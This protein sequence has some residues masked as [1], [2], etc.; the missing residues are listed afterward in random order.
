MH[1]ADPFALDNFRR[2][3]PIQRNFEWQ[4]KTEWATTVYA[5]HSLDYLMDVRGS[6]DAK[7]YMLEILHQNSSLFLPYFERSEPWNVSKELN[8]SL[9]IF[10]WNL[11]VTDM[12]SSGQY[13]HHSK[14]KPFSVRKKHIFFA[15][16]DQQAYTRPP[17]LWSAFESVAWSNRNYCRANLEWHWRNNLFT[18]VK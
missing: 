1:W 5:K 7:C 2:F 17:S 15:F 13:N 11:F 10:G 3:L 4:L 14:S 9:P 18:I 12:K 6:E 8:F 16:S